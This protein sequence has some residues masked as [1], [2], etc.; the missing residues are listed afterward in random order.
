LSR[1]RCRVLRRLFRLSRWDGRAIFVQPSSRASKCSRLTCG[2]APGR[3]M[4]SRSS[5]RDCLRIDGGRRRSAMFKSLGLNA[6]RPAGETGGSRVVRCGR[7]RL[8]RASTGT[9]SAAPAASF[10]TVVGG[11]NCF[12]TGTV[13]GCD[14]T[15]RGS[16]RLGRGLERR[17][18]QSDLAAPN[19]CGGEGSR[20]RRC[21]RFVNSLGVEQRLD[22]RPRA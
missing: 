22:P 16:R 7:T 20:P 17:S 13:R 6:P 14:E 10:P 15:R 18:T 4:R 5:G 2:R 11:L 9:V 12:A 1:W 21:P 19:G 3:R 8:P